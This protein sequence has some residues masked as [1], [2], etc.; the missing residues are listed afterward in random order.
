[1]K[2]L[3]Q[4]CMLSYLTWPSAAAVSRPLD[5]FVRVFQ[6]RICQSTLMG[7]YHLS[8]SRIQNQNFL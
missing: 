1:L 4:E 3:N 6:N 7:T 8:R 5:E 2:Y